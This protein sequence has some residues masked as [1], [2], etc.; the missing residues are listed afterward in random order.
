MLRFGPRE[1][2][3]MTQSRKEQQVLKAVAA[4]R[5]A[6]RKLRG[7]L[8]YIDISLDIFV[9]LLE[10]QE[11]VADLLLGTEAS[12]RRS[13]FMEAMTEFEDKRRRLRVAVLDLGAEQG[14]SMAAV[15]KALGISRQLAS[16]LMSARD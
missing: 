8:D 6:I 7:L 9:A 4:Y 10:G 14:E 3:G 16:R 15:A 12:S 11:S 2:G 1:Q 5:E 13:E